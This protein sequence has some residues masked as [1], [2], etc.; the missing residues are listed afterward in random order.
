VC[1]IV[2]LERV[3]C[4]VVELVLVGLGLGDRGVVASVGALVALARNGPELFVVVHTGV[5]PLSVL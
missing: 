5:K 3:E 2:L 1:E 4:E